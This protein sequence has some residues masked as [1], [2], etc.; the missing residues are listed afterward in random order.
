MEILKGI[1]QYGLTLLVNNANCEMYFL[2]HVN[3]NVS[4]K[5]KEKCAHVLI[6]EKMEDGGDNNKGKLSGDT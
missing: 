2:W 1:G 6:W 3:F 5:M 4:L